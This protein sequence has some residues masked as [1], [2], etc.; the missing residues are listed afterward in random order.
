MKEKQIVLFKLKR[1]FF[2]RRLNLNAFAERK[3]FVGMLTKR[4]NEQEVRNMFSTYG[5]IEECTVL[6]DS[7]G[8]SKG[9]AFVTFSSRQCAINAIRKMHHS[10]T[11]EVRN[12][13]IEVCYS[14]SNNRFHFINASSCRFTHPCGTSAWR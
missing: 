3:L 9:C 7:N 8:Q 10:Q 2:C 6:R 4:F 13:K 14:T 12:T 5:T 1:W 11:M